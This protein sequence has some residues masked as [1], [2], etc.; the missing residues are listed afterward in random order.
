M[1]TD[2]TSKDSQLKNLLDSLDDEARTLDCLTLKKNL[3]ARGLNPE[4]TIADAKVKIKAA[5]KRQRLVWQNDARAKRKRFLER[6]GRVTRWID[7]SRAEIEEAFAEVASGCYGLAA[8]QELRLAWRSL[9]ELAVEDKAAILDS[10]EALRA[11]R[12]EGG[13]K[14]QE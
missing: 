3:Q 12:A 5:L 6:A 9:K 13:E 4:K 11:M 7:R 2:D 14:C 1:N 8:Q 10:L